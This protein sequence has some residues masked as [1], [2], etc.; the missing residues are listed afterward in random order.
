MFEEGDDGYEDWLSWETRFVLGD[1]VRW[2]K[3][4]RLL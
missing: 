2:L 3:Q 4:L 1:Y